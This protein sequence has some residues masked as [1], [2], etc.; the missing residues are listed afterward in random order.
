MA[1]ENTIIEDDENNV[2]DDRDSYYNNAEERQ[3]NGNSVD[4][5]S[6]QISSL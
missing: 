4:P 1:G 2:E 6:P 3:Y 5:N